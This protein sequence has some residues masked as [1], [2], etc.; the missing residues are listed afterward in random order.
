[1]HLPTHPLLTGREM[2]TAPMKLTGD[3]TVTAILEAVAMHLYAGDGLDGWEDM[4]CDDDT[5]RAIDALP[6]ARREQAIA[7]AQS[8]ADADAMTDGGIIEHFDGVELDPHATSPD[9]IKRLEEILVACE[10]LGLTVA[11]V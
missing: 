9:E 1:M 5:R 4:I 6:A 10:A 8:I 2:I 3:D 11:Y 7:L